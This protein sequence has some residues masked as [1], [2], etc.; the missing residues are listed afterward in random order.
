MMCSLTQRRRHHIVVCEVKVRLTLLASHTLSSVSLALRRSVDLAVN[1]Q[2]L[3]CHIP[4]LYYNIAFQV[5]LV[6][7]V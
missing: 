3:A 1:K 2:T 4:I 5:E 6:L 7:D